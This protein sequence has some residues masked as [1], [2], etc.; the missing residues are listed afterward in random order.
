[1]HLDNEPTITIMGLGNIA[2]SVYV[3][4]T[5]F[6]LPAGAGADELLRRPAA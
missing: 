6:R 2:V 1:M 3:L 4:A 5:L